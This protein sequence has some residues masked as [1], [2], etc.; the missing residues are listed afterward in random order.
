MADSAMK[1]DGRIPAMML[2]IDAGHELREAWIV[3]CVLRL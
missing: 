2:E 1:Q 3:I